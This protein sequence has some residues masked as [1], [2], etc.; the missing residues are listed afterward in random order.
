MA[1]SSSVARKS[2]AAVGAGLAT[3]QV[4]LEE[5]AAPEGSVAV[6]MTL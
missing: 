5:T 6:T 4:K 3:V 2:A 1:L